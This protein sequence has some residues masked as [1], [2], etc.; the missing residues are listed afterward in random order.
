ML[1]SMH[2]MHPEM[3][4]LCNVTVQLN[5]FCSVLQVK[6]VN[7]MKRNKPIRDKTNQTPVQSWDN[8][9]GFFLYIFL[10]FSLNWQ[11]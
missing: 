6:S 5:Y 9:F 1:L 3:M 7:K 2:R 11:E 8:A 10:N 4:L